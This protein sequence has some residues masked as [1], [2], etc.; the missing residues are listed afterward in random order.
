[1]FSNSVARSV[2]LLHS[3]TVLVILGTALVFV[4]SAWRDLLRAREVVDLVALDRVFFGSAAGVR[5]EI[6]TVGVA[7]LRDEDPRPGLG[8]GLSS[9]TEV[10]RRAAAALA[11]STLPDRD[12]L[13]AR[14][15]RAADDFEGARRWLDTEAAL[16]LAERD[17]SRI[18]PWR[19]S[20]YELS[21]SIDAASFSVGRA[22]R[23]LDLELGELVAI[24][25]MSF[26]IRDRYSRQCSAFR[27]AVQRDT[28][29]TPAER[30]RWREDIGAYEALW[31]QMERIAVQLPDRMGFA[32]LVAEGRRR[33]EVAQAIMTRT[34]D[35]LSGS[36]RPAYDAAAWSE[37]CISAY[38][39]ILGIGSHAL[40]LE[41][42]QA[43]EGRAAAYRIGA[44][45]TTFLVLV[46]VL[47]FISLGFVR[48]RLSAPMHDIETSLARLRAGELD[49]PIACRRGRTSRAPSCGRSRASGWRPRNRAGCACAS[50]NCATNWSST[51]RRSAAPRRSSSPP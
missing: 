18:E 36:G 50:T 26:T 2:L 41:T 12:R 25:Q 22:L 3:I 28:P 16:P 8:I 45:S 7:L 15:G 30:D 9:T 51:P 35:G 19:M 20:V 39:S 1:M 48:K 17:A 4:A 42:R 14:L 34:L 31:T 33:T 24:R 46:V 5:L 10:H 29:L 6:G 37:N 11:V 38:S 47:G 40:D 21:A 13:L 27:P 32:P 44:I 23:A 43:D 49:T